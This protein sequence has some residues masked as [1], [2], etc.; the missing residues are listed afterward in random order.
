M[1]FGTVSDLFKP[2]PSPS[3]KFMT[4]R[5]MAVVLLRF[6]V[7]FFAVSVSVTFNLMFVN[8]IFSS[9]WVTEWPP[10]GKELLT[11]LTICSLCILIIC[12]FSCFPFWF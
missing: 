9:V 8:I 4:D 6:F 2:P 7:A 5:S 1:Q 10:F 3:I 12:Y 11:R